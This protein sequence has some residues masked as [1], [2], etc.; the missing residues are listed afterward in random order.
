MIDGTS[1]FADLDTRYLLKSA[2][3]LVPIID[4]AFL[5]ETTTPLRWDGSKLINL[6]A[7]KIASGQLADARFLNALLLGGSRAMT[8][9]LPFDIS[10]GAKQV[11]FVGATENFGFRA[12]ENAPGKWG[13]ELI[14]NVL[15]QSVMTWTFDSGTPTIY[16]TGY[17][18]SDMIPSLDDSK[19]LGDASLEWHDL[20]IDGTAYIDALRIDTNSFRPNTDDQVDIGSSTR[21][22]KDAYIDGKAYIDQLGHA[23]DVNSQNLTNAGDITMLSGKVLN[24]LAGVSRLPNSASASPSANDCY[25]NAATNTLYIY[26][27]TAWKSVTLS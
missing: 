9:H 7:D 12:I 1:L 13:L 26:N 15:L 25:F 22:F 27:G 4:G 18:A 11:K 21:E 17:I 8:G 14:D 10:T 19:N 5:G 3:P 23:L 16:W 6:A 2:N 24:N 20:F